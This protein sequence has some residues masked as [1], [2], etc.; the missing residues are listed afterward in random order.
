MKTQ[1]RIMPSDISGYFNEI[2]VKIVKILV[3]MFISSAIC[4]IIGQHSFTTQ[5]KGR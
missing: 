4:L 2:C 3:L 1:A 5:K